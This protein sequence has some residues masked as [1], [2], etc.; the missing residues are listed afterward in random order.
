MQES[1]N[2]AIAQN[3]H[4]QATNQFSLI[5]VGATF[6]LSPQEGQGPYETWVL[7]TNRYNLDILDFI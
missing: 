7:L 4:K 5:Q 2:E 1:L 6:L 3:V